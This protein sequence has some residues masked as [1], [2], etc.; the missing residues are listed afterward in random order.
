MKGWVLSDSG[1]Q[2][3]V[4]FDVRDLGGHLDNFSWVVFNFGFSGS[5]GYHS[6]C[7]DFYSHS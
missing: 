5:F 3:S 4:K 6:A 1:D 7:F 2:W